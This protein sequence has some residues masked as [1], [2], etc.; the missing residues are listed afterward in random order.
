MFGGSSRRLFVVVFAAAIGTVACGERLPEGQSSEVMSP[1]QAGQ[2]PA[3]TI[4]SAA[5]NSPPIESV[6]TEADLWANDTS[7]QFEP[8]PLEPEGSLAPNY[9]AIPPGYEEQADA[10]FP[11]SVFLARNRLSFVA[12]G[13]T[14]SVTAGRRGADGLS[15][16]LGALWIL[17]TDARDGREISSTLYDVPDCD[18]GMNIEPQDVKD[19][20]AISVTCV[21]LRSGE[22]LAVGVLDA[23]TGRVVFG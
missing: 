7:G 13:R 12:E 15:P 5:E 6:P 11:A 17:V 1:S 4:R 20:L 18:G 9:P 23:A 8:L 2:A 19:A 10:P 22:Q 14:Y 16:T 3:D 21:E